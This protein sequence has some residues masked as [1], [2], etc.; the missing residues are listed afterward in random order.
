MVVEKWVD[1]SDYYNP[2][3]IPHSIPR[4]WELICEKA[5]QILSRKNLERVK[6]YFAPSN[7]FPLE[8]SRFGDSDELVVR[9]KVPKSDIPLKKERLESYQWEERPICIG[10]NKD[11]EQKYNL[12]K[13]KI[14]DFLERNIFS[15]IEGEEEKNELKKYLSDALSY[16]VREETE[17][18]DDSNQN[19]EQIEKSIELLWSYINLLDKDSE[20]VRKFQELNGDRKI[21]FSQS[22]R[23]SIQTFGKLLEI[24]F[25]ELG[26]KPDITIKQRLSSSNFRQEWN[27][28]PIEVLFLDFLDKIQEG[29]LSPYRDISELSKLYSSQEL[30]ET[31]QKD[32][33]L[34][35]ITLRKTEMF[36]GQFFSWRRMKK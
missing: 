5:E 30:Y 14:I 29:K 11:E 21:H 27:H 6:E 23:F 18:S 13:Q 8:K 28:N 36:L 34:P 26:G 15:Q 33:K 25:S 24:Y 1:S 31:L 4:L 10:R 20:I 9:K 22:L 32:W 16:I 17:E 7:S 2:Q 35:N 19:Q 12:S 3:E